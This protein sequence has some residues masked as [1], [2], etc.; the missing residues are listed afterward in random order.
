M[1]SLPQFVRVCDGIPLVPAHRRRWG[2]RLMTSIDNRERRGAST[3]AYRLAAFALVPLIAVGLV[4]LPTSND[5]SAQA[6]TGSDF[7]PGLIISDSVFF[8][9]GSLGAADIQTFLNAQGANCVSNASAACLK[10]YTETT[11]TRAADAYCAGYVG[12]PN[13]SAATI[14]ARVAASCG[15]N[16]KVLLV[17]L[18]KEQ[19][20]ITTTA[21]TPGKLRVAMGYGCP[22]TAACN[23]LYYGFFN[24]VYSA[25]RQFQIYTKKP[26]LWNYQAGRNNNIQF[27]PNAACGS[28]PVFIQNQ[29]TANLYIYT[30]Y[31]PNSAAL[32]NLTGLGDACSSY[33]NRNFWRLYNNWFGSPVVPAGA[34]SA[35]AASY[36]DV[37]GR[38]G[39]PTEI[40]WWMTQ[41][42]RGWSP[43]TVATGFLTS[44]EYRTRTITSYYQTYLG[45][46]A[47]PSDI[48]F[49][50]GQYGSLINGPDELLFYIAAS[51]EYFNRNN[52]DP[53]TLIASLYRDIL[54]RPAAPDEIAYWLTQYAARGKDS[55]VYAIWESSEA[56]AHR[57]SDLYAAYL[58]RQANAGDI[59]YWTPISMAGSDYNV[60]FGILTSTEYWNRAVTRF[61]SN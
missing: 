27:N 57:I 22:D 1:P 47:G 52:Q 38:A 39:S 20:L 12:M 50:L 45:R 21:P 35:L 2:T 6:V 53:S 7:V 42:A 58:G 16:P 51:Q 15:I 59:G 55:V 54:G 30:P 48:Q 60:L 24:Q 23:T 33:G 49:W 40:S 11:T 44:T 43:A 61:P 46:A 18:E 36:Q 37:L 4:A 9:S 10:N 17:T 31:Q 25:A 26:T 5:P 19:G 29:A 14:V 56:H 8:D 32:A 3:L 34:A 28:T 13:E 41:M